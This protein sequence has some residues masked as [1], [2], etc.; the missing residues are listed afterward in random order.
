MYLVT[1]VSYIIA[2]II[3]K[4]TGAVRVMNKTNLLAGQG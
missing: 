1:A 4:I 2:I 3:S